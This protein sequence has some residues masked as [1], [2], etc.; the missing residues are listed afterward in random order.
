VRLAAKFVLFF[1]AG[2]VTVLLIYGIFAVDRERRLFEQ[3]VERDTRLIARTIRGSVE[4]VWTDWGEAKALELVE[5]LDRVEEDVRV[6]WIAASDI[7][8]G[9]GA[10][11]LVAEE[12]DRLE[13]G[14]EF[15]VRHAKGQLRAVSTFAPVEH[16]GSVVGVLEV[17]ES[18]E[19]ADEY[20]RATIVRFAALAAA[21]SLLVAIL[22]V[23][24]GLRF[25]G[26]PLQRLVDKTRRA[27]AGDFSGEVEIGSKD[28]LGELGEAVNSMCSDL[29]QSQRRIQEESEARLAA[30]EQLRHEDRL[31]TVG[32]LASGVAHELGTPL[33][34]VGGRAG[35]IA[36]GKLDAS[37]TVDAA[38]IIKQQA[39]VMTAIVRQLLDFA[40]RRAPAKSRVDLAPLVGQSIE[41]LQPMASKQG[42][43]IVSELIPGPLEADVDAGQLQQVVTNLVLNAIQAS[44]AGGKIHVTVE[45]RDSGSER[46]VCLVVE[47]EGQGIASADIPHIFE[48]F[49]TTKKTGEGTG[50]GLSLVY[51]IVQ[52]HGG[53]VEVSSI[54]GEG[55]RFEVFLPGEVGK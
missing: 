41:L 16:A 19:A 51:G 24:V 8:E 9:L 12:L 14:E 33:N 54:L 46:E 30:L 35:L 6:R 34:V 37:E 53:R 23:P 28:E 10:P 18:L 1:L 31:K 44:N 43:E 38:R 36:Q 20:T 4:S 40:R 32:R 55:T 7:R 48:P 26:S 17:Q 29:A 5:D 22:A 45:A 39:Q 27:G 13:R 42:V 47:D 52:E 3:D 25:V 15:S 49:F 50:L 2:T 11:E 21:I